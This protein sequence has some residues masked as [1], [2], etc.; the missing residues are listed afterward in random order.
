MELYRLPRTEI[1]DAIAYY[2]EYFEE[3]GP[4]NE[5]RVIEELGNPSKIATQIKANYAVKQLGDQNNAKQRGESNTGEKQP[6]T[7]SKVWWVILGV[8]GGIC[9]APVAI[10]VAFVII[11]VLIA[12]L[13]VIFSVIVSIGAAIAGCL[14]TAVALFFGGFFMFGVSVPSAVTCIGAGLMGLA[15][16]AIV[17]YGFV[18]LVKIFIRFLARKM[19]ESKE[20]KE[21][22]S[23]TGG[24]IDE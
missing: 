13:A 6:G 15:I 24:E 5:Q 12:V 17:G 9:A 18:K 3:A 2:N 21:A 4:E 8:F 16:M 22:K 23:I 11:A 10:P 1:D 20:K 7:A 19:K 14:I